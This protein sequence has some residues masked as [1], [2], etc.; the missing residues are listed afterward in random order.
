MLLGYYLNGF[1]YDIGLLIYF[2][3]ILKACA[4]VIGSALANKIFAHTVNISKIVLFI[5]LYY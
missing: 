3:A 1:F 4:L 2:E 5:C